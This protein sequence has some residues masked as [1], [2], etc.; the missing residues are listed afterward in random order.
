MTALP[1]REHVSESSGIVGELE[2]YLDAGYF[3]NTIQGVHALI[4]H[5]AFL[6]KKV[7]ALKATIARMQ[8][9]GDES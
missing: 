9:E 7:A 4:T 1:T 3:A 5:A 8:E 6:E 2:E